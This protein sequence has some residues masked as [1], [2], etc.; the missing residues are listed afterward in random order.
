LSRSNADPVTNEVA[1][2]FVGGSLAAHMHDCDWNSTAVG[3]PAL[4]PQSLRSTIRILLTSRHPMWMGWGKDLTLFYNDAYRAT[5]GVAHPGA[6]GQPA[7]AAWQEVWN[8]LAP[9][10]EQVMS[11]GE[12][13][14]NEGMLLFLER[15]GFREE[16]Y[17]TFCYSPLF[18]DADAVC[19]LLCAVTEETDGIISKRRLATLRDLAAAAASVTQHSELLAAMGQQLAGNLLDLP[20]TL[21]YTFEDDEHCVLAAAA[22]I[23][24]GHAAAPQRLQIGSHVWSANELQHGASMLVEDLGE[25]LGDLPSGAWHLPPH[26]ALVVPIA[27]GA[28]RPAGF[29]VAAINPFRRVDAEYRDFVGL[30]ANQIAGALVSVRS[31]EQERQRAAAVAA[32]DRAKTAFLSNVSHEFR[33]PLTLMLGPLEELLNGKVDPAEM[34]VL[35]QLAHRSGMRLLRLVNSLLDFSRIEA[36]RVQAVYE[37]TDLAQLNAEIAAG[38]RPTIE[39]AGL[40]FCVEALPLSQVVYVDRNMWERV[41]LNLLSNAFKYTLRGTIRLAVQP[42]ADASMAQVIVADSGIGVAAEELPR[43]FERFHRVEGAQGRSFE[44]TG[45]GLALVQELVKLHGGSIEAASEIGRGTRFTISLPFGTAHLPVE[46]TRAADARYTSVSV[47][48]LIAEAQRWLPQLQSQGGPAAVNRAGREQPGRGKRLLLVDDNADMREYVTRLLLAQG[49]QVETAADGEAGLQTARTQHIDLVLTDVMMPKLDG[50]GLLRAIRAE[51]QLSS[52]P[53][54]MLSARAGEE[55]K[56]EGIAA[57]ADDYLTKPFA[58]RELLARIHT[59]IQMATVRRDAARAIMLSEQQL[60]ISQERL[61]RAL[62]TGRVA[63]YEWHLRAERI[64]LYGR[65]AEAFGVTVEEAARGIPLGTFVDG[66]HASDRARTTALVQQTMTTGAPFQAEYRLQGSSEERTVLSRGQIETLPSGERSFTGVLIDV[67]SEKAVERQL[68]ANERALLEQTRAL[69]ILNRA[70][71]LIAGEVNTEPVVQAITDAGVELIGAQFGAFFY[72]VQVEGGDRYMLYTLSG[73]AAESFASFPMPRRTG[74]FEPTFSGTAI[75]RCDDITKDPRY[76]GSAPYSGMPPGHLPVCSYLAVPVKSAGGEVLGGLLFGHARP[77]VFDAH[78]EE[79]VTGL[80]ATAAV[81]MDNARLVQTAQRELMHRRKAETELQSLNSMLEQRVRDEVAERTRAE[82]AL[83]QVQKMEAVGQLTGG[84]AHDFNNLLTVIIGGLDTIRRCVSPDEIRV[85]RAA[86][87]ALQGAQRAAQLTSRLLAFSRRQP[88]DPKPLDLN[89]MVRDMTELLHRTLGETIELE[90]ILSPRLWSA[91]VDQNQLESAIINLAVNAR[92]A[93]TDGGKLTIET[94][95]TLLDDSYAAA[96]AEVIPGQYVMVSV[97]DTGGGMPRDVLARAFEPFFTTKEVG[98]G[99]GLGL[100]MVYGFVKQSGG[101]VT[102][103]SEPKLGT[104]VKVY[105]PRYLGSAPVRSP[106][107]AAAVPTANGSEVVLVV[108]DN[109]EVRSYSVMVLSELGYRVLEASDAQSALA[110]LQA[111]SVDLL[112][113]DVVLPGK[114]G[115]LLAEEATLGRPNLRVL[116]TTGYSRDAIVHHGRLDP[117]VHLISKPFTFE[118]LGRRVREVLD[119]L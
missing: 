85:R 63:V 41:L 72:N 58:T 24:I 12:A 83:R 25:K 36:G 37:P 40:T 17:H 10:V 2:P 20:F 26:Q 95:N 107:I 60:Q 48:P 45:I 102:I 67:T 64:Y 68:R 117:G 16:T 84:V 91:E 90:G 44:G 9:L 80:A 53:V 54:I 21:I 8:E 76:G 27:Q 99:T 32:I 28:N 61:S 38:F 103:S 22:G 114:S 69:Q 14:C 18:D 34:P 92:D 35:A 33:T 23:E 47:Q 52:I 112:F 89:L 65:L 97:S 108:E 59:N 55:A 101:H 104:T 71:A 111:T 31:F 78:H 106:E 70:A 43:L 46:R 93:M 116:Y 29:L 19:G 6:L 7:A 56:V 13:S 94:A 57:G 42:S 82:E 74:V 98:K 100:S 79:L 49:Y 119:R 75:V 105:F 96:D 87:L 109:L 115:R 73:A 39:A 86:D 66:I 50:F 77:A 118:A 5:L 4:W 15:S 81:A 30:V 88:L 11:T 1:G 51:T 62:S 113:T 3:P 110:T